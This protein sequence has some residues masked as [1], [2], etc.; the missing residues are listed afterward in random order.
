MSAIEFANLAFAPL[1]KLLAIQLHF[2][3][4]IGNLAR[5]AMQGGVIAQVLLDA[6]IQ[7]QRALLEDHP[8]PPQ[9]FARLA[10]QT[11]ARH[12]DVA[13]LQVVEARQQ[14]DQRRFSGSVGA[15]QGGEAARCRVETDVSQRLTFPVGKANAIDLQGRHGAT[16]TPQG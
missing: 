11:E 5:H 2:D 13:L 8:K 9:G 16:T 6:E 3:P 10:A 4:V 7:V 14:G 1:A 15:E 12:L